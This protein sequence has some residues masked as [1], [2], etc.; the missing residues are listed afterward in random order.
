MIV[1]SLTTGSYIGVDCSAVVVFVQYL[2]E[3]LR[4]YVDCVSV[5]VCTMCVFAS[6]SPATVYTYDL[7]YVAELS[8]QNAYEHM[9]LVAALSGLANREQAL[10]YTNLTAADLEWKTYLTGKDQWLNQTLFLPVPNITSLIKAL[11]SFYKGVVL[12]DPKVF[13]TSNIA[14]T[15]SGVYNLLPVCYRPEDASS[16]YSQLVASGPKLSV[17]MNLVAMFNGSVSG[18][19]K[20]DAYLWAKEK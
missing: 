10:L 4:R 15:I 14:S 1:Q 12:Y 8:P 16:L 3:L 11:S 17:E 13:S 19:A 9:H 18:S 5:I 7:S 2:Q 6:P 20:C